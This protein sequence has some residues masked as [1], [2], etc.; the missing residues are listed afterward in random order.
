V[1]GRKKL[2]NSWREMA[3]GCGSFPAKY[4]QFLEGAG[5]GLLGATARKNCID[6]GRLTY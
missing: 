3:G 4:A 5:S 1:L 2:R 6:D